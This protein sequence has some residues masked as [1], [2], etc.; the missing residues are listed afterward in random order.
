MTDTENLTLTERLLGQLLAGAELFSVHLGVQLGLYRVLHEHPDATDAVLAKEAGIAERYAR[1]WLEQQAAAGYV[2]CTSLARRTFRLPDG[3]ADVLLDPAHP[4]SGVGMVTVFAGLAHALPAVTA[5][6]RTGGGVPYADFGAYTRDGIAAMNLPG[7]RHALARE[8]LPALPDVVE[9]LSAVPGARV[10]DLGCG[11]G[12]STLALAGA[13]P[14]ATVTGIDLD[15]A[16]IAGARHAAAG[17]GLADRVTFLRQDAADAAGDYALVTIFEALHDMGDPVGV[18]RTARGL[19]APGGVLLVADEKV[20][21]EFTAPAG[22][23]ERLQYAFSVLH[24]LPA[25]MAE[26]PVE[27][28][29]TALRAP[30]VARWAAQAGLSCAVLPIEHDF[31]RFYRLSVLD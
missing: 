11:A 20:G 10:L 27:A 6:Y 12:A 14:R 1:E 28:A 24:C 25:T 16:S 4:D 13:F 2:E 31:W 3:A 30:T 18:L 8:W 22:E 17:A 29:G 9:R 7:F 5:A 23:V 26:R 15:D 21:D 19:L